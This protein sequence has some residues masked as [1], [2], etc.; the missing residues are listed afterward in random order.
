MSCPNE[1]QVDRIHMLNR[2]QKSIQERNS[3]PNLE[4]AVATHASISLP[5]PF[6]FDAHTKKQKIKADRLMHWTGTRGIEELMLTLYG[7]SVDI[8]A[9]GSSHEH[10]KIL[11]E[12]K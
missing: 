10:P 7:L 3:S 8:V 5:P 11:L 6:D 2:S 1:R 4:Q 9:F 12:I